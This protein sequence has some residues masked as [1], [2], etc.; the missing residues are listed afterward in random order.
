[1]KVRFKSTLATLLAFLFAS[2]VFAQI[3]A[4]LQYART[5]G[6]D[7][8]NQFEAPKR[9]NIAFEGMRLNVGGDFAIQ[10]QGL[11][12]S[13]TAGDLIELSNNMNLPTAN[14]NLDIQLQD[15][16]RMHLRTYLSSRHHVEAWVKGGYLQMDNLD[17]IAD[18]FLAEVMEYTRFR[19]GMDEV[20]YGDAHFRRSDNAQAI[21]NPFVENY[22][23]DSF[24]TEPFAEVSVQA[25]GLLAVAGLTNGR[26]NQSPTPGD[27]GYAVYGKLGVDRQVNDDLRLRLTGSIYRS[28]SES[29]RDYLYGGDR[30]GARYYGIMESANDTR[31]S[32]FLPR[33][34]P[35][36]PHLTALQLNPFVRYQGFEFFG[37]IER[38]ASGDDATGGAYTQFGGELLYR[39]GP[40]ENLY[41][42]GRYNV[43]SGNA[44]DDAATQEVTRVN[45]GGGWFMT[46]N[47]LT[48]LEYVTSSYDGDGF[49]GKFVGAEY[50]GLMIEAVVSF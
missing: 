30:A 19:F 46:N 49:T 5:T 24:T 44:T 50:D 17:F 37:I 33:F 11:S 23:M 47:V 36:F 48:K 3:N 26:L 15:G 29:T 18:G 10:F 31:V 9:N 7:G 34:N 42:G 1:M 4:P 39:F 38:A 32:D 27:D 45:I 8:I 13:N 16:L 35:G 14:L 2:S 22:L 21:Y 41:V 25:N 12:Q 43:V 6:Q 40:T 28:S 20:N